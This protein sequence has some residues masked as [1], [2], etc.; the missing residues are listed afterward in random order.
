MDRLDCMRTF[1]AVAHHGSFAEAARHLR[2]SSSAASRAVAELE[3]SLG[4]V[5]FSRTTRSVTLTER[6]RIYLESCRR[7]L[8]DVDAAEGLARGEGAAPRGRLTV[9]APLFFGRLHV[10]PIVSSL[11]KAEP[12]IDVRLILSDRYAH[13]AE[14]GI[15]VAVR[16]GELADS[17]LTAR[18][19]GRM[20]A[21][22]VASPAYL[23]RAGMPQ[24]PEDL[25]EHDIISFEAIDTTNEWRLAPGLKPI[26]VTPRLMVNSADAAVSAAEA[27]GGITR[28]ISYQVEAGVM[29][30]RLFSVLPDVHGPE[31][32]VHML[33]PP[34][35]VASPNLDAFIAHADAYF[36]AHP[37]RPIC[38]WEMPAA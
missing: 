36:R 18:R 38:E 3:A 28:V 34:R 25:L 4:L 19:I 2:L 14:E 29:A 9:A 35:R 21:A 22:L 15:D 17:S 37:I 6:G 33:Y 8:E 16:I 27:G 26:R 1:V 11:L 13:M 23:A 24:V 20:C 12:G 7:I 32:P 30:G 10:L 5:L 31:I